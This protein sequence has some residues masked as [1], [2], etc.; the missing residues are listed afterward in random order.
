MYGAG[1]ERRILD[2]RNRQRRRRE[3]LARQVHRLLELRGHLHRAR[4][5][6]EGDDHSRYLT[7]L[8][9][10]R[11]RRSAGRPVTDPR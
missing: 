7:L 3:I 10:V 8:F 4:L 1:L 6:V 5:E 11:G 9:A 2:P